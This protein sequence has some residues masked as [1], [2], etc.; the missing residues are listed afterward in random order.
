MQ[1]EDGVNLNEGLAYFFSEF[2]KEI[3]FKKVHDVL[4][5]GLPVD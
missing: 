1:I 3:F 2:L 4:E 5:P